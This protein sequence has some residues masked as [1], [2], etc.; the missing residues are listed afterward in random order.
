[1]QNNSGNKFNYIS[2]QN[3]A[4]KSSIISKEELQNKKIERF[5]NTNSQ[6]LEIKNNRKARNQDIELQS[7]TKNIEKNQ[8]EN[9]IRKNQFGVVEHVQNTDKTNNE[10]YSYGIDVK[11]MVNFGEI[12]NTH[13]VRGLFVVECYFS[14]SFE[15]VEKNL[16]YFYEKK[17]PLKIELINKD[18]IIMSSPLIKNVDSAKN[19]V[20]KYLKCYKKDIISGNLSTNDYIVGHLIGANVYYSGT[21]LCIGSVSDILNF[22]GVIFIEI[23]TEDKQSNMLLKDYIEF[24]SDNIVDINI[25][26]NFII[27]NQNNN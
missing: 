23:T 22:S 8:D 25:K 17:L 6:E 27:I 21:T 7:N 13:G 24:N 5:Q 19:M 15:Y 14:N 12:I 2:T 16:I 3:S 9:E 18:E 11:S 1:M 4:F 20:G 10:N 26:N